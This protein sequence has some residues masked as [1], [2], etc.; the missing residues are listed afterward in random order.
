MDLIVCP[1]ED[2][3]V[4]ADEEV[5]QDVVLSGLV[6]VHVLEAAVFSCQLA[7]VRPSPV[8]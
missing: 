2:D 3:K 6:G 1:V 7:T 4:V 8:H 5:A